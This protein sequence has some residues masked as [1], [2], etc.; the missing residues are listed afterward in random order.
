MTLEAAKKLI[1][2]HKGC[3]RPKE[4]A[5]ETAKFTLR[6]LKSTRKLEIELFGSNDRELE[7]EQAINLYE[8]SKMNQI[9][10]KV[11]EIGLPDD[12]IQSLG[13]VS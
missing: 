9:K 11:A 13:E 2:S 5:L 7:L 3:G 10:Q 8:A 12:I 6:H 4:T 1:K